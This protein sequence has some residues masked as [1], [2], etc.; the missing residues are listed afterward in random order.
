ML[1]KFRKAS[2]KGGDYVL[3]HTDLAKAFNCI[4]HDLI[5]NEHHAYGFDIPSLKLMNS[6]FTSILQRVKITNS[7]SLWRLIKYGFSQGL[8]L[9]PVLFNIFL[10]DLFFIIEDVDLASC[11]DD[12]TP[13]A[14]KISSEVLE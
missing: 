6:Y 2:D 4:P 10:C 5:I 9:G 1:E 11:A 3:F 12:N 14:R 8:I 13:Y 7:Y